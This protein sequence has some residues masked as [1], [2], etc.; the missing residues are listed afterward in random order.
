MAQ[1]IRS[2]FLSVL[3]LVAPALGPT[4]S[5]PQF[6]RFWFDVDHV[7]A[8]NDD[9]GISAALK[10]GFTGGV[11]GETLLRLLNLSRAKQIDIETKDEKLFMR[12]ARARSSLAIN[13]ISYKL[14]SLPKTSDKPL[15]VDMEA[16]AEGLEHCMRSVGSLPSIPESLGITFE[17]GKKSLLLYSTTNTAL[18]K[19][20]VPL[21]GKLTFDRLTVHKGFCNLLLTLV[22]KEHEMEMV[23]TKEHALLQC[24][25]FGVF[26]RLM[27]TDKP[28]D[29]EREISSVVVKNSEPVPIPQKLPDMLK[30]SVI[31]AS[32]N[33]ISINVKAGKKG[34]VLT[35][36]AKSDIG[37]MHDSIPFDH[38]DISVIVDPADLQ[39]GCDLEAMSI[40]D[41]GI[42]M[43][44]KDRTYAICTIQ[45]R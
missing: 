13:D 30:R 29:F 33:R 44:K 15:P 39:L 32:N 19:A 20:E 6:S 28:I 8:Y 40:T 22:R 12:M 7:S 42:V 18:S 34:Q 38:P 5:V 2:E 36:H 17:A 25:G 23:L 10:T 43:S 35:I 9:I 3:N 27:S 41:N 45:G 37:E 4:N 14:W 16:L 21:K 1:L 11:D 31:L 26:G 24:S